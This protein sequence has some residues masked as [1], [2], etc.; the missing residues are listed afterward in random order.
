[1][2]FADVRSR[3]GGT[4]REAWRSLLRASQRWFPGNPETPTDEEAEIL[5]S[6]GIGANTPGFV[7]SQTLV[8]TGGWSGPRRVCAVPEN[9]RLLLIA[10][11]PRPL[12]RWIDRDD[13]RLPQYHHGISE[14]LLGVPGLSG[15]RLPM[16]RSRTL[17]K[18]LHLQP[19]NP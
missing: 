13:I 17:L 11:G 15:L 9:G 1:M 2:S 8:D 3:V 4:A 5:S 7:R 18:P 10:P 6:L 14:L 12:V 19:A 16:D